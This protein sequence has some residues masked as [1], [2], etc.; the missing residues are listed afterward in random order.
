MN[1]IKKIIE[2]KAAQ[3]F[4]PVESVE[5]EAGFNLLQRM[6]LRKGY[7]ITSFSETT[8]DMLSTSMDEVE[9]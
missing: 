3:S 2:R 6:E 4:Q 8:G 9:V 7:C 5:Q 1:F